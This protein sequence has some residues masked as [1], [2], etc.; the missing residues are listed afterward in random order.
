MLKTAIILSI[1]GLACMAGCRRED[2]PTK[3]ALSDDAKNEIEIENNMKGFST[4]QSY[5]ETHNRHLTVQTKWGIDAIKDPNRRQAFYNRLYEIP[6]G[7][8]IDAKDEQTRN[9]Q[10]FAFVELSYFVV[11]CASWRDDVENYWRLSIRRFKVIRDER[12]RI[13]AFLEGKSGEDTYSGDRGSWKD[14]RGMVGWAYKD[15]DKRMTPFGSGWS[16]LFLPWQR[17]FEIRDELEELLGHKVRVWKTTLET[18][19]KKKK[20]ALAAGK[21]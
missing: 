10:F 20:E 3:T 11:N 15:A 12:Q 6:F 4:W 9:N 16:A 17:W 8:R 5:L 7:F 21:K 13:K 2:N 1:A 14:Y 19:E 18:V